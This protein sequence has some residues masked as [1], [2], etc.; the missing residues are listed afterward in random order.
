VGTDAFPVLCAGGEI[1]FFVCG[2]RAFAAGI[3]AVYLSAGAQ[4]D[5]EQGC[6]A[7]KLEGEKLRCMIAQ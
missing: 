7:G 4:L 1:E 5:S 6:E 3:A 2:L